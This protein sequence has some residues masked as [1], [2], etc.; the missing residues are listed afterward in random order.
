MGDS[1]YSLQE[2]INGPNGAGVLV[3]DGSEQSPTAAGSRTEVTSA[4]LLSKMIVF[5]AI[6][7]S[8]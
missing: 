4:L 6:E 3:N 2:L 5:A 1:L 7:L 8:T